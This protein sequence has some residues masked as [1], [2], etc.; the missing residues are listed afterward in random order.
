MSLQSYRH[1]FVSSITK[2]YQ[3][4]PKSKI[5][6]IIHMRGSSYFVTIHNNQKLFSHKLKFYEVGYVW[7]FMFNK[8]RYAGVTEL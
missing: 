1:R 7:L 5:E 2:T 4:H 3:F 6:E 8:M